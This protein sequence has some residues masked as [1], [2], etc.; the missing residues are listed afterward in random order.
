MIFRLRRITSL[1]ICLVILILACM[2]AD[3]AATLLGDADGDGEVTILDAT[4][5]QRYL[6]GLSVSDN[7][8]PAAADVD[9]SEEIE[10]TDA[11]YIQ[12]WL[13][14][15]DTPYPIGEELEAPTEP[16]AANPTEAPAPR[17]TDAEGWGTEIFRP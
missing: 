9:K 6:A 17:P 11:T 8:S 14:A 3:A 5:I 16:A 13:A 10:I 12:R 7:F 2:A 4:S 15:M 1:L